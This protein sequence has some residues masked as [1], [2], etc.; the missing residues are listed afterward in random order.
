VKNFQKETV[1]AALELLAGMGFED[2][3]ELKRDD[4]QKRV[5]PHTIKSFEE[6][7]PPVEVG[8]YL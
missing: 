5:E 6:L 3:S 1:D 8:A 4:I 2:F 7:Y